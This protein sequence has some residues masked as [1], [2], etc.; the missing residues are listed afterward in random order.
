MERNQVMKQASSIENLELPILLPGIRINTSP[1]DYYPLEQMRL[2]RFDGKRWV[3]F[4]G[5]IGDSLMTAGD[6]APARSATGA[7]RSHNRC[8]S[9]S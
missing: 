9:A 5:V 6:D 4:G 1:T 2:M 8:R 3:R 7:G